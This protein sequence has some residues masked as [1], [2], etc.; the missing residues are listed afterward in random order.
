MKLA[1]FLLLCQQCAGAT[2]YVSTTG[3]GAVGSLAQPMGLSNALSSVASPAQAGDTIYLRG[4]TYYGTFTSTLSAVSNNPIV[5]RN[6][7]NERATLDGRGSNVVLAVEGSG[8]W[9]WGLEIMN[10]NPNRTANRYDGVQCNS[11]FAGANNKLI[12][13]VIHDNADGAFLSNQSTNLEVAGCIIYNNGYQGASPDRGHGHGLYAQNRVERKLMRENIIFNQFG[14]GIQLYTAS[15]YLNNFDVVGN[16]IFNN[17]SLSSP[18]EHNAD[19][20]LLSGNPSSGIRVLS[21][22]LYQT[23]SGY[24]IEAANSTNTDFTVQSNVLANCGM[25]L[26]YFTNLTVT[27]NTIGPAHYIDWRINGY[28]DTVSWNRNNYWDTAGYAVCPEGSCL[29]FSQWRSAYPTNDVNGA[30]H[31]DPTGV[32]TY[33]RANPYEAGRAHI[34]VLNWASNGT[35]NVDVSSVLP[36]GTIYTVRNAQD[37]YGQAVTSG[38]YAG[39]NLTLPTTNLSVATPVGLS[40]PAATGPL[41]NVY[42]LESEA[43]T[44]VNQANIGTLYLR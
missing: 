39:G 43:A 22:L 12:N 36:V 15:S 34:A 35:V 11:S 32:W 23:S 4:G 33:V 10:S 1:V 17:G 7:A 21:N 19:L 20:L 2:F 27:D 31:N 14:Y 29:T 13:L 5:I 8:T 44:G 6:Y 25:I 41:F 16:T 38:I 37:Y 9:F 24:G 28:S 26:C 3:S 30:L 18:V 40:S 42:A